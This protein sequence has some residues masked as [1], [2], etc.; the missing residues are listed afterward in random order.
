MRWTFLLVLIS[1]FMPCHANGDSTGPPWT[2]VVSATSGRYYVKL[3]P[4]AEE[5]GNVMGTA[6]VYRAEKG[7]CD[8]EVWRMRIPWTY[9]Y[10]TADGEYLAWVSHSPSFPNVVEFY[11]RGELVRGY[12]VSELL[13][14]PVVRT[15][16]GSLLWRGSAYH[17]RFIGSS[18][19]FQFVTSESIKYIIEAT[20]GSITSRKKYQPPI[21]RE[22]L[23][24]PSN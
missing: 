15:A 10:L 11:H 5:V 21:N 16:G 23:W 12:P 13:D 7:P 4:D 1:A 9:V 17:P 8:A 2:S 14:K 22:P 6:I 20:E 3:V 18:K 19:L 24:K